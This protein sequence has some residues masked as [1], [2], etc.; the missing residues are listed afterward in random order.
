MSAFHPLRTNWT[1]W[2]AAACFVAVL[3]L[4]IQYVHLRGRVGE[5]DFQKSSLERTVQ[6]NLYLTCFV[7]YSFVEILGETLTLSDPTPDGTTRSRILVAYNSLACRQCVRDGLEIL[8]KNQQRL[9]E[10]GISTIAV[11]GSTGE[12][13][14]EQAL[15]LRQDGLLNFPLHFSDDAA[16][17]ERLPFQA[18][19]R[20][21]E[22]P[23]FFLVDQKGVIRLAFKPDRWRMTDVQLWLDGILKS[24]PLH[25]N[26]SSQNPSP[27][28]SCN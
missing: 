2:A 27:P 21:I 10:G 23:L 7:G 16:L 8:A 28:D 25:R 5:V 24:I 9:E 13:T 26:W 20:S 11:I 22:T 14:R 3:S 6:F 18:Q 4:A 17:S 12:G 1:V 15:A 19:G